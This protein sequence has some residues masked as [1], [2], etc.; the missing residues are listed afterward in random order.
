MTGRAVYSVHQKPSFFQ[1]GFLL[2]PTPEDSQK[3]I[4]GIQK[5]QFM[6]GI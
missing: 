2:T 6:S 5:G 3:D 1:S 4:E